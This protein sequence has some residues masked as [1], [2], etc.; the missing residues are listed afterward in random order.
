MFGAQ[1]LGVIPFSCSMWF[2]ELNFV[3]VGAC[4]S[5]EHADNNMTKRVTIAPYPLASKSVTQGAPW[6]GLLLPDGCV[7]ITN[8]GRLWHYSGQASALDSGFSASVWL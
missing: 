1:S 8:P 2:S 6:Y 4:F 3:S 7:R 5:T